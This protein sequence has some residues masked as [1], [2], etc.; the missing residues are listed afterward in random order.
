M[1]FNGL[2]PAQVIFLVR[3]ET[4][5]LVKVQVAMAVVQMMATVAVAAVGLGPVAVAGVVSLGSVLGNIVVAVM[6]ERMLPPGGARFSRRELIR[7]SA[8]LG[9]MSIMTKVYLTVDL[10]LLGWYVVGVRL[11]DYAAASKLLT[12]LA[13]LAGVV[14][15]GA[16]PALASTARDRR[17]LDELLERVWHWLMIAAVP[18]FVALALFAP[19]VIEVSIGPRYRGAVTLM[20]ILCAA[21]GVTVISNLVGN[22]MVALHNIRQLLIQ[23]TAAIIVNVAGNLILIPHYGVYAAAWITVA[24]EVLVCSSCV[25]TLRHDLDFRRLIHVSRSPAVAIGIAIIAALPLLKS[26]WIA[27]G[28]S[29]AAFLAALTALNAWPVEIEF[30]RLRARLRPQARN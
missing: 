30:R 18:L 6:A 5:R 21:G 3:Y 9:I 29:S 12:V 24:T 11:G 22:L 23:N 28:V 15:N 8:P 19:L 2:N 26:Q 13:G 4:G 10:V 16:L 20:R 7:R 27:A 17:R 14:M 1:A 25:Y